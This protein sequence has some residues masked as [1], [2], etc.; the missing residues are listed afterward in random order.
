MESRDI[1]VV[2]ERPGK[3]IYRCV[4]RPQWVVRLD[5]ESE[6]LPPCF[7]EPRFHHV[8]YRRVVDLSTAVTVAE[9]SGV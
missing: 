5:C 2:N 3:G 1:F 6:T 7:D 8:Q 4:E 9:L